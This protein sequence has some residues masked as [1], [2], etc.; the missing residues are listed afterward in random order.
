MK[1][2]TG[3]KNQDM[4]SVMLRTRSLPQPNGCAY[5]PRAS[6]RW[7]AQLRFHQLIIVTN[8]IEIRRMPLSKT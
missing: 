8:F 5:A 3:I 7:L 2:G 1:G 6:S 4:L